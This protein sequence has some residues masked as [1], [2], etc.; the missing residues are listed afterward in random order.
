MGENLLLE[1]RRLVY[2]INRDE[3]YG[4]EETITD[5]TT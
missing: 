2:G 1:L 5:A 4:D 3:S